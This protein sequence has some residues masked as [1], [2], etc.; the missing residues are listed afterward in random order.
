MTEQM[1]TF[2]SRVD[3]YVYLGG[4]GVSRFHPA[5]DLEQVL[6]TIRSEDDWMAA[7]TRR[8]YQEALKFLRVKLYE[9]NLQL[10]Q[11]E[12]DHRYQTVLPEVK[13]NIT[14]LQNTKESLEKGGFAF[15][16]TIPMYDLDPSILE[17]IAN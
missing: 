1:M 16:A 13:S 11:I 15:Q 4:N 5:G 8:G 14:H 9:A 7:A 17:W 12:Y 10:A 2:H 3:G 6:V